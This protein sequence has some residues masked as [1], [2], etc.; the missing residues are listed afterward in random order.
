[1]KRGEDFVKAEKK[2]LSEVSMMIF[3]EMGGTEGKKIGQF[4]IPPRTYCG[5]FFVSFVETIFEMEHL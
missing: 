4:D 5:S 2:E 3:K 1:M